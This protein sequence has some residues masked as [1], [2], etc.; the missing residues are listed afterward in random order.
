MK[1]VFE[2]E[3]RQSLTGLIGPFMISSVTAVIF[4]YFI[5]NNLIAGGSDLSVPMNASSVMALTFAVPFLT[6]R[7]FAEEK[8]AGTDRLYMTAPVTLGAVVLGKFL[9]YAVILFVPTVI[10]M[11]L[12]LILTLYGTVPY[13]YCYTC[14][15]AFYL[16]ALMVTAIG[17]FI[18]SMTENQFAAGIITLMVILLGVVMN[19]AYDSISILFF[20]KLLKAVFDFGGRISSLMSGAF[21]L[22]GVFYFISVTVLF[23]FLTIQ[24]LL[25]TRYTLSRKSFSVAA[26]SMTSCVLAVILTVLVNASVSFLPDRVR[27]VDVTGNRLFSVTDESMIILDKLQ[28]DITLFYLTGQ[29]DSAKDENVIRVLEDYAAGSG[30]VSLEYVDT[31]LNP[32]FSAQY[33][34]ENLASGSV[35]AVNKSNG[36]SQAVDYNDMVKTSINFANMTQY[37]TGYDVE[38]CV[39][40]AI[41]LITAE[42]STLGK[43][44]ATTGHNELTFEDS[45]QKRFSRMGLALADIDLKVVS[46]VPSDCRFLVIFAPEKDFSNQEGKI[47][48]E[49]L[50]DGGKLLMVFDYTAEENLAVLND[51]ADVFGVNENRGIVIERDPNGYYY[52]GDQSAQFY[53]FPLVC[54]DPV[55]EGLLNTKQGSVFVPL[56]EAFVCKETE[57]TNIFPLLVSSNQAFLK[58]NLADTSTVPEDKDVSGT[59]IMALRAVKEI[60]NS[61]HAEAVFVGSTLVFTESANTQV[62]ANMNLMFFGNILNALSGGDTSFVTVPVK[63]FYE[64]LTLT[65]SD[66]TFWSTLLVLTVLLTAAAGITVF[67]RRRRL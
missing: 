16:Y 42:E 38:G 12:P 49:Y 55:T 62:S 6:M 36:K 33:T 14:I 3:L 45:F 57:D 29:D 30:H 15:L 8:K 7:S 4:M 5:F 44:Y 37:I 26:Y 11:F 39:T 1:A 28:D 21:D 17:L 65:A 24:S 34:E 10:S 59:Q 19:S 41:Q 56:S 46:A 52:S 43:V 22:T 23:L 67:L 61:Q 32:G 18:S 53:I 64:T 51:I 66:V 13:L 35:I 50:E 9:A 58:K 2:K 27:T 54:E 31:V 40:N 63:S 48:E 20:K 25:S 47:V 60:S